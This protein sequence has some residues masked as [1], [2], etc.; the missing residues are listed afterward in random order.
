LQEVARC[1][2]KKV[3]GEKIYLNTVQ[4]LEK[5]GGGGEGQSPGGMCSR[6]RTKRK[7]YKREKKDRTKKKK[8]NREKTSRLGR[9]IPKAHALLIKKKK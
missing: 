8:A 6:R 3:D 4:R 5:V 2:K 9:K 7:K 1:I